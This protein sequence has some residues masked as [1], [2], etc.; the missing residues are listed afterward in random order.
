MATS[1][2]LIGSLTPAPVAPVAPTPEV[3]VAQTTTAPAP[4]APPTQQPAQTTTQQ[5]AQYTAA[6]QTIDPATDTQAGR[7]DAMLKLT[8]PMCSGRSTGRQ[9]NQTRVAC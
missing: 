2:G 1:T 6:T 3:P 7:L 9:S 8:R 5:P 4:I